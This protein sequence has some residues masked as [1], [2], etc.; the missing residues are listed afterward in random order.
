M[1]KTS[2]PYTIRESIFG[3]L[4]L[5]P[6]S[7]AGE[8]TADLGSDGGVEV[9]PGHL[10][11]CVLLIRRHVVLVPIRK[12]RETTTSVFNCHFPQITLVVVYQPLSENQETLMPQHWHLPLVRLESQ[13]VENQRIKYPVGQRVLLVQKN[14]DEKGSG[15]GVRHFGDFE[16]GGGRVEDGDGDFGD[17]GAN[18]R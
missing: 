3:F 8:F 10:E 5:H 16:E 11:Q 12:R 18:N 15:A 4:L 9:Y 17:D 7:L 13:K 14:S 2:E 1:N 6:A